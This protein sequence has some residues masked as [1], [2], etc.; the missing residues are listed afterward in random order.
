MATLTEQA[1]LRPGGSSGEAHGPAAFT[2]FNQEKAEHSCR[3]SQET[4]WTQMEII[5]VEDSAHVTQA[6]SGQGH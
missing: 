3:W 6:G 5:L 1:T 2:T 4:K